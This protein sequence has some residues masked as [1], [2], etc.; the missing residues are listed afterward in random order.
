MLPDEIYFAFHRPVTW[1]EL[2]DG[3]SW[4]RI[5]GHVDAFGYTIDE[6]WFFF[7]PGRKGTTLNITHMHEEV[8]TRLQDMWARS[9][10]ILS[11]KTRQMLKFPPFGPINCVSQCAA[12]VGM[13]A[14]TPWGLKRKLLANNAKVIH[15]QATQG[16]SGRE[17]RAGSPETPSP[18]GSKPRRA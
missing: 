5:F 11:L 4:W 17:E 18:P 8:E 1:Q 2:R 13:R 15:G 9:E 12:L 3:E 14:F 16:R 10:L 7:E 6:T